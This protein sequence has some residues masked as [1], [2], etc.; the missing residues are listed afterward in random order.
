M[1]KDVKVGTTCASGTSSSVTSRPISFGKC[2]GDLARRGVARADELDDSG[3]VR[4]AQQELG[5]DAADVGGR[6]Q[7]ERLIGG[8][9][10]RQH[11]VLER[12]RH[13]RAPVL[14]EVAG[15][16]EGHGEPGLAQHAFSVVERKDGTGALCKLRAER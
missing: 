14:R 1:P 6:D 11:P 8:D 13:Y 4:A 3:S 2:L 7:R 9:E 16:E 10:A 15:A 5:R 12:D